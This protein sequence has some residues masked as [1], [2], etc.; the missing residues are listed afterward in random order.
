MTRKL[1]VAKKRKGRAEKEGKKTISSSPSMCS[2]SESILSIPKEQ[3]FGRFPSEKL[4]QVEEVGDM[5]GEILLLLMIV[6]SLA[7]PVLNRAAL[8][9]GGTYTPSRSTSTLQL[10]TN[11]T[12]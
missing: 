2:I 10:H 3:V 6:A 8:V 1:N 12:R 11:C 5:M 9:T 4:T 7:T